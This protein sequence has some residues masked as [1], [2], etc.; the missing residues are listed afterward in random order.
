MSESQTGQKKLTR[1]IDVDM[2]SQ[3]I[4]NRLREVSELHQLGISLAKARP[5]QPSFQPSPEGTENGH[6]GVDGNTKG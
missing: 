4:S 6:S 2:S 1:A 3:A 5:C